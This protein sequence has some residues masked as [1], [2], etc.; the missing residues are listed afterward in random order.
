MGGAFGLGLRNCL[1]RPIGRCASQR[2]PGGGVGHLGDR[3]GGVGL[4]QEHTRFGVLL[5]CQWLSHR[6]RPAGVGRVVRIHTNSVRAYTSIAALARP[7][8]DDVCTWAYSS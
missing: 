1:I 7:R 2:R 8:A 6:Q 5:L 4:G 3:T